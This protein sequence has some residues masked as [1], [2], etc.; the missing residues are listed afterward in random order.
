MKTIKII[1][2]IS[3]F[4][5]AAFAMQTAN[6]GMIKD[7]KKKDQQTFTTIKGK[8]VDKETLNALVF[9]SVTLKETNIATVTNIDGE[10]MIKIPENES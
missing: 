4:V 9:A 2:I 10:F 1:P 8:V 7:K 3:V 5:L 6:A